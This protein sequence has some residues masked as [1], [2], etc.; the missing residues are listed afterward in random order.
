MRYVALRNFHA[1]YPLILRYLF[2]SSFTSV[3]NVDIHMEQYLECIWN[4][5]PMA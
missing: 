2:H 4:E 5:W 3:D 1:P